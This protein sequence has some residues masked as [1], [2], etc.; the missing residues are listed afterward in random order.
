MP[1]LKLDLPPGS[2]VVDTNKI[3]PTAMEALAD[4][5]GEVKQKHSIFAKYPLE[6]DETLEQWQER[7]LPD[8]TNETKKKD[9]EKAE[10]YLKRVFKTELDKKDL[11]FDTLSAFAGVFGGKE[12]T[13]E[14][15]NKASYVSMKAFIK[16]VLKACDFP[17]SDY[18]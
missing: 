12:V 13:K 11:I 6:D 1:N 10:D 3:T 2:L 8:L 4:A 14:S 9:G 5:L 15:F 17:T 7:V 16:D 18:E